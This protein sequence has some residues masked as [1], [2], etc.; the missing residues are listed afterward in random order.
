MKRWVALGLI[1]VASCGGGVKS[2]DETSVVNPEPNIPLECYTDTGIVRYGKAVAN[3]CYVCHTTA[4][5]PYANEVEDFHLQ[6]SY[7]FPESIKRIGNPWLNAIRPDLTLAGIPVPSDQEIM[8]YIR[9]DNWGLAY[10][11][12][13]RGDL[14]YFPD[15]PPLYTYKNGT[16]QLINVDG[17]GF[18]GDTGWRVF[19][20]KPFPGFFPTNG[21][22]DSTLIRLAEPFRKKNGQWDRETY[23]KNLAIVECAV[24]GVK[25]GDIC[26]GTELGSFTMP[27][28]YEGD[29]SHVKVVTYQ[30]PPGT[31]FAH[32]LYYLDPDNPISF[33]SVRIREMRYMKKL[34][35]AGSSPGGGE[36]EEGSFFWDKGKVLNLS[37]NWLMAGFIEDK[38]GRLRP[39]TAEEMKFCVS[40]HGG[41][42]GTVDATFT[43]WRKV[44]GAAGWKEQD[45]NLTDRSI[46]DWNY[47]SL[48]G[49]WGDKLGALI[50]YV[51][52]EYQLYFSMT[53]GGDHFRSNK[54]ILNKISK[55]PEKISFLLSPQDNIITNPALINYLD[56]NGYIKPDLFL[57]SPQRALGIDK[58]YY[59]VVRAQAFRFGRD[60]FDGPFGIS[61]GGNSLE[62]LDKVDSTGVKESG[63]WSVI[64]T[65]LFIR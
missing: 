12:R 52:G 44:P 39:Q 57:P 60:V 18:V 48:E 24:K 33:K 45:Y 65:L 32:P 28:Y 41:I 16:Y 11:N 21:R 23:K 59:R 53:A 15:V 54:E 31:E 13:G 20:W 37:K 4:N 46:K 35:Y 14:E 26:E 63:I 43:F 27:S 34:A 2:E 62:K 47:S 22:I 58:Q 55:D 8:S 29:A 7:S 42:G 9:E 10:Q 30:Y 17:E 36:E 51:T 61:S 1:L 6:F 5:T 3:P 25:P 49:Y 56:G 64:K 38:D 40:C 50:S 19:K